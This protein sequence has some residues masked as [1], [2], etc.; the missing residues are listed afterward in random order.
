MTKR[1]KQLNELTSQ[2]TDQDKILAEFE[3]QMLLAIQMRQKDLKP[4]VF[5]RV[6]KKDGTQ[7]L[8]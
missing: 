2:L 6:K 7:K 8:D 3:F 1:N 5:K 4:E